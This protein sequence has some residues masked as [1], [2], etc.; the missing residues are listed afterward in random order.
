MEPV[1]GSVRRGRGP[2]GRE[3]Y[4]RPPCRALTRVP[5]CRRRQAAAPHIVAVGA[6]APDPAGTHFYVQSAFVPTDPFSGR[7]RWRRAPFARV[8]DWPTRRRRDPRHGRPELLGQAVSHGCI[9][10][11]NGVARRLGRLAPLAAGRHPPVALARDAASYAPQ[12]AEERPAMRA[13]GRHRP[14]PR[15]TDEADRCAGA[16]VIRATPSPVGRPLYPPLRRARARGP[17]R[18]ACPAGCAP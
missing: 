16:D 15:E 3:P 9:R 5:S 8:T 13:P 2:P 17:C 1:D 10:V 18:A 4:R 12:D 11:A 7:S 6:P 14:P